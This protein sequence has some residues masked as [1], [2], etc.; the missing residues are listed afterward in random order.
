LK[1]RRK[2]FSSSAALCQLPLP[3][4]AFCRTTATMSTASNRC[5]MI[6]KSSNP[7]GMKVP[8]PLP[9]GPPLRFFHESLT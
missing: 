8:A 7:M 2:K 5:R 9:L 3:S 1:P 6:E 4:L